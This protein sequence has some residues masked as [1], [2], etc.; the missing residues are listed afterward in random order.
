[1][2]V[3]VGLF[4]LCGML[5]AAN[6]SISRPVLGA[7]PANEEVPEGGRHPNDDKRYTI[8]QL[9]LAARHRNVYY[10][11][12]G[13]DPY[14]ISSPMISHMGKRSVTY[15]YPAGSDFHSASNPMFARKQMNIEEKRAHIARQNYAA[16]HRNVYLDNYGSDPYG[17]GSPIVSRQT[18]RVPHRHG[19]SAEE[20]PQTLMQRLRM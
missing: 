17:G 18:I 8:E 5:V 9:N 12:A 1:M 13:S 20:K 16:R 19:R 4:C 6:A 2:H 7:A 11:R 3:L 14:G 10:D 15:R